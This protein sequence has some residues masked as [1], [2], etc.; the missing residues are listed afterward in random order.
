MITLILRHGDNEDIIS[1]VASSIE[2]ICEK[3]GCRMEWS[4][5]TPEIL[6]WDLFC[7][8]ER[9]EECARSMMMDL[10]NDYSYV[11]SIN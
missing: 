7:R 3:T 11:L 1:D 9:Q 5:P 10:E 4:N 6:R 2:T 8:N